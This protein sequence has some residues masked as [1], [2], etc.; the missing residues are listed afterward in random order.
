MKSTI[1]IAVLALAA[2]T[3]YAQIDKHSALELNSVTRAAV[4][5]TAVPEVKAAAEAEAGNARYPDTAWKHVVVFT[6]NGAKVEVD[7][8]TVS[9]VT[10]GIYTSVYAQPV[11]INVTKDGLNGGSTVRVTLLNYL[12]TSFG[13][14]AL[15][16]SQELTLT[17]A[18]GTRYTAEAKPVLLSGNGLGRGRD[19]KQEI[20]VTVDGVKLEFPGYYR[21]YP[22]KMT[23]N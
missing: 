13:S 10:D 15:E 8:Q 14:V 22:F 4:L 18:G 7:Y 19:Y 23:A 5:E 12:I 16:N 6:N 11:W 21:N 3:A 1:A 20:A 9:Q 2:N 17:H